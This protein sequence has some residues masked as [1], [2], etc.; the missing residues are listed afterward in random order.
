MASDSNKFVLISSVIRNFQTVEDN[1]SKGSVGKQLVLL[2]AS[3][4]QL[5]VKAPS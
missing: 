4:Y 1:E 2:S 3:T 5:L